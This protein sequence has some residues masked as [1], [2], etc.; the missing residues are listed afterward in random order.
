[1]DHWATGEMCNLT[2]LRPAIKPALTTKSHKGTVLVQLALLITALI[3]FLGYG[4]Y[5][6]QVGMLQ[7]ELQKTVNMSALVG[8]S[9]LF[10]GPSQGAPVASPG[11]AD[12]ASRNAFNRA[13]GA[14]GMLQ[15]INSQLTAVN[16]ANN[17]VELTAT[18]Q[19]N[20]SFLSLVGIN[21]I[22][23]R[24]N[25]LAAAA[26]EVVTVP[27]IL[28][29]TTPYT[30]I[31]LKQPLMDGPGPDMQLIA[32]TPYGYLPEV[33]TGGTDCYG[34]SFASKPAPGGYM[35]DRILG[36]QSNRVLFGPQYIDLGATHPSY[37]RYVKKASHIK[38][39]FSG[40]DDFYNGGLRY[41]YTEPRPITDPFGVLEVYHH[42]V[43]C[44]QSCT[45]PA[46]FSA[47]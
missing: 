16:T 11:N 27:I 31:A 32:Q 39:S 1:M 15:S 45:F 28:N 4:I 40:W 47:M 35:V 43:L 33:C 34:I 10:D 24:V 3:G 21:T 12:T 9:A 23:I 17:Q 30:A 20:T 37:A 46:G 8:A 14:S 41:L 44:Y 19:L 26:K 2:Q 18:G 29:Q 42:S 6:G 25:A 36:G 13:V 5:Y 7:N 38:L 22:E